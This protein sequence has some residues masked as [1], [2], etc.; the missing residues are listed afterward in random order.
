MGFGL[1][2]RKIG[3]GLTNYSSRL[4]LEGKEIYL[5]FSVV[6]SGMF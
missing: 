2:L 5:F 1:L 4:N 6:K 3:Q